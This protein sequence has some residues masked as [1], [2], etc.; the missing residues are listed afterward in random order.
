MDIYWKKGDYVHRGQDGRWHVWSQQETIDHMLMVA[1]GLGMFCSP[2]RREREALADTRRVLWEVRNT[3]E[4]CLD[5]IFAALPGYRAGVHQL[6]NRERVLVKTEPRFVEPREGE[7]PL[8]EQ[9]LRNML[10]EAPALRQWDYLVSW[11]KVGAESVMNGEPGHWRPGHALILAGPGGSG[12]SFAQEFIITPL[13]GGRRAD[14]TSMLFKQDDYNSDSIAAEHLAMGEAPLPS[15]TLNERTSFGEEIKKIVAN[16]IQRVRVMRVDPW[17]IQ[18]FWRLSISVNDHPDKL[19]NLPLITD[20]IG[21][22]MI[23]LHCRRK[24]MP[25]PTA[26][27]VEMRAFTDAIAAE[28]PHFLHWLLHVWTIPE[29]LLIYDDGR[30]ATRFGFREFHHPIIKQGLFEDTPDAQF[31]ALIDMAEFTSNDWGGSKKL[32]E[33]PEGSMNDSKREGVWHHS[34]ETLQQLLTGEGGCTC[35][36]ATM[37]KKLLSHGSGPARMLGRLAKDEQI[38]EQGAMRVVKTG[39][40][41]RLWKGWFISRP[42]LTV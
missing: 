30:K 36:V 1:D 25:M 26:T 39:A 5:E 11:L 40:D 13:L 31:L 23:I 10:D 24:E 27:D 9:V 35:S 14:P 6:P 19:R 18:P 4:R 2:K 21:D 42:P 38:G 20:D 16:T 37:I 12:K 15:R 29:D 8:I 22:K 32:W 33:L 28:M 34:S 17:T 7:W 41:T 3:P